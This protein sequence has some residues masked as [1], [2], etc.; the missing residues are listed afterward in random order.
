MSTYQTVGRPMEILLVEDGVVDARL[1]IGALKHGGFR[2]RL[3]LVRDG[4]EAMEFLHQRGRFAI[5]P[6]PDLILLD[7]MLPKKSG[8]DVLNE[9][10]QDEHLR[11]IPV[12]VMTS[13]AA[14]EDKLQ[15][16]SLNVDEYIVKP[17]NLEKFL[18]LVKKLKKF[19]LDDVILPSVD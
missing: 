12:V 5:V 16:R 9:V 8:L 15:C 18:T 7:L 10:K 3:T 11:A 13:S 1:A 6:R 19:W 2:H 17:L 14:E 4:E